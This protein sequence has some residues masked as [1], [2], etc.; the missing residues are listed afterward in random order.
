MAVLPEKSKDLYS[1]IKR[2]GDNV[3][4][5]PTQC[6]QSKL[7]KQAKPQLCAN[8]SL[9][10]NSKLGGINHVIDPS[11][12]SPV[13]REPVIF[14]ADVTHLLKMGFH[15]SLLLSPVWIKMQPNTAH[16]FER[17]DTRSQEVL[18]KLLKI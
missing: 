17:R 3:I 14:G 10:I 6:V 9:K 8:I 11:K 4:G 12:K 5:I 2:V 7:V 13:F 18:R 15:L 1:E 16:G